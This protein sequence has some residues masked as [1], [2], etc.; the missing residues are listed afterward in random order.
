M[1]WYSDTAIIGK[2]LNHHAGLQ[3]HEQGSEL[4]AEGCAAVHD[5]VV[6]AAV[7]L[8]WDNIVV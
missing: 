6:M 7:P 5:C 3:L 2:V 8:C 4:L 1:M